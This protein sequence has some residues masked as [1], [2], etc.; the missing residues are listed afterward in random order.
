MRGGGDIEDKTEH[1]L[2][3]EGQRQKRKEKEKREGMKYKK[4]NCTST[5]KTFGKKA[6]VKYLNTHQPFKGFANQ[7]D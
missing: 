3:E 4:S 1:L 6:N 5:K 2:Y 7:S